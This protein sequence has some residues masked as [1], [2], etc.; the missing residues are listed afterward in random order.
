[1]TNLV[2]HTAKHQT[3]E[4]AETSAP[5]HDQVNTF[6]LGMIEN[7]SD[8]MPTRHGDFDPFCPLR[9]NQQLGLPQDLFADRNQH[10]ADLQALCLSQLLMVLRNTVMND[11][12]NSV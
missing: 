11:V 3:L 10:I 12:R 1:M 2:G 5:H 9:S 4:V 8:R 7:G 6:R